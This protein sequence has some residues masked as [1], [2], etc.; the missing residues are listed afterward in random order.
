MSR[1]PPRWPGRTR[2]ALA[3]G[4]TH[5]QYSMNELGHASAIASARTAP[6]VPMGL[7]LRLPDVTTQRP[8]TR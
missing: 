2:P 8:E 1:T 6:A 7:C 5:T 3:A 4:V